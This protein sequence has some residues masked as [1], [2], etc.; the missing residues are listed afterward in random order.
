MPSA[1][2]NRGGR[3]YAESSFSRRWRPVSVLRMGSAALIMIGSLP[4]G[5]LRVPDPDAV[6]GMQ[7]LRAAERLLVEIGAVGR[8]E[9]LDHQHVALTADPSVAGRGEWIV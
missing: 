3:A 6:A 4:V 7:R 9:I 8:A 5:E 2:T 1:T